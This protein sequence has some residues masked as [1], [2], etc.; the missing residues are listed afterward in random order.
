MA[1]ASKN[2]Q[3]WWSNVVKTIEKPLK[4]MVAWK[5]TLII[6]SL[7][8]IDHRHGP[9]GFNISFKLRLAPHRHLTSRPPSSSKKHVYKY[10]TALYFRGNSISPFC[11]CFI[12][13]LLFFPAKTKPN[14][15]FQFQHPYLN[16][17]SETYDKPGPFEN[18]CLSAF[19][20]LALGLLVFSH[21]L[22]QGKWHQHCSPI[23]WHKMV[24]G[25]QC[26]T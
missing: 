7:S 24:T 23:G 25:R 13:S 6:P 9:E 11:F 5:K 12:R 22:E 26:D 10:P 14:Q 21:W 16:D 8:K 4:S 15:L 18:T 1:G 17:I 2:I 3:W 20:L 19:S